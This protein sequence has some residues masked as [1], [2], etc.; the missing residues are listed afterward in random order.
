MGPVVLL[1]MLERG[2]A[3]KKDLVRQLVSKRRN[4]AVNEQ[5]SGGICWRCGTPVVT[6]DLEQWFLR[7]TDY[8]AALVDDIKRR[9]NPAGR[10]KC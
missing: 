7:I 5:S 3:Y 9:S 6:R 10:K 2:L 8:A 1:Q 4:G